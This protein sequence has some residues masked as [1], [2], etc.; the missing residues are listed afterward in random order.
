MR[1]AKLYLSPLGALSKKQLDFSPGM[2]V[3]LGPNEAGKSTVFSAVRLVLLVSTS[4]T[5]KERE[6]LVDPFLPASG[7]DFVRVAVELHKGAE[8]FRLV[9]R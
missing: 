9:R 2:N 7:G 6:R 3:V 5:K 1:L 8:V 4:L